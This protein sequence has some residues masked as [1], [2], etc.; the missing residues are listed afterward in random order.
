L[1]GGREEDE[2]IEGRKV[3]Q[4]HKTILRKGYYCDVGTRKVE[5]EEKQEGAARGRQ[6]GGDRRERDI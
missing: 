6:G 2:H 3:N 1:T 4:P 5:N